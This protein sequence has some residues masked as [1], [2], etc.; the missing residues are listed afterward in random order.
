MTRPAHDLAAR[1]VGVVARLLPATRSQ[2]GEAMQ[3]ELA[4][5]ES[6]SE[7]RRFALAC[8]RAALVPSASAHAAGRWLAGAATAGLV[9]VGEYALGRIIG[10]LIPLVLVLVLLAWLGR[11]A[12][13]FGPV[14][15]ELAARAAR[16]SGYAL[17]AACL[18]A[19]IA[20]QGVSGLLQ[21]D[22]LR[23]A[24]PFAL[25]LTLVTA[26]FLAMT[27]RG[28]RLGGTALAA[29]TVAGLVA[30]AAGFVVLPF[31]R[32][33]TPLAH[34]LPGHGTWLALLVFGAP[35]AA[36]LL[37]ARRTREAEQAVMA[38]LCAGA[39]AAQ[40]IALA[41]LSAIV[42]LPDRVPDIVGPVMPAGMTAAQRQIENSIEASDPY[43]GLLVFGA[44]L[45]SVLWVMARPPRRAGTTV[46][47]VLLGGLPAFALAGSASNFPGATAIATAAI[48]AVIGAV[49][50]AR[51]AK[52]A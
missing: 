43:F 33:G 9:L 27:A 2:W 1:Y 12:S 25:I 41:G 42:L 13:Y 21:P 52:P 34:A 17:V 28:S 14:R 35:A 30:G 10:Q 32:D 39:C 6:P 11:R 26:A 44:L 23:W 47:L 16:T 36:A 46:A 3:A 19:L 4:A 24:P 45:A 20:A 49:L 31:E 38:A 5:L 51:P 7:R 48:A 18:L 37:T 29:G 40:L 15:P 50:T 8:T 22:S